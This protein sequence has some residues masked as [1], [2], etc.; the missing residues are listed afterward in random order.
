MESIENQA[1]LESDKQSLFF[2]GKKLSSADQVSFCLT[3]Y[4]SMYSFSL[5]QTLVAAGVG[6]G[7]TINIVPKRT[8]AAGSKASSVVVEVK[9]DDEDD[10]DVVPV[11]KKGGAESRMSAGDRAEM[12][13]LMKEMGGKE[14]MQSMM[15]QM[16]LDG[17]MT[18]DK[19]ESMVGQI[20][21]M[22]ENPAIRAMFEDPEVLE[23]SRQQILSNPMLMNAY[24]SMGMGGLIRD[25]Q[26]FRDQMEGM[27]KMLENPEL[28]KNAMKGLSDSA[29]DDFDQGEL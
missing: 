22:F 28:L 26:A 5:K 3:N 18:P 12:E 2:K 1:G 20:K 14:S 19:I 24:D 27:K 11:A 23:Q 4:V 7:D 17:P 29:A 21:S 9:D 10:D 25:P 15:K 13:K 8:P 16:G 6:N